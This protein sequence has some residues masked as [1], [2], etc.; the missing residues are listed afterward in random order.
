MAYINFPTPTPVFPTLEAEGWS[1]HKKPILASRVSIAMTGKEVQLA[2]AAF[3]RWAFTLTYGWLRDQTQNTIIDREFLG[4]SEFQQVSGIFILCR[5]AYGEFFYNDPDD[6]SRSWQFVGWGD[7]NTTSFRLF[8]QWGAG[9]ATVPMTMPVGGINTID[10]VYFNG[11]IQDPSS[12]GLSPLRHRL[13]F[14]TPPPPGAGITADF[15]FYYRCRFLDDE[16]K[17]EQFVRNRWA[18]KEVRFESVKE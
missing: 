15:H 9:P 10:K 6:N 11:I 2:G 16:L 5:G 3:P 7:G 4:F 17:F 13:V 14:N 12:Y 8:Y 18:L 1:V